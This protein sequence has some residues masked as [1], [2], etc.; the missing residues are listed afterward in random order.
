MKALKK[1]ALPLLAILF[2]FVS[3]Y[4]F[5]SCKP[6]DNENEETCDTCI[7]VYKPNIY[8]YPEQ[9]IDLHVWLEFPKGGKVITSI[10]EYNNGWDIHVTPNGKIN[11]EYNYLFYESSQ[12]NPFQTTEGWCVEKDQLFNFFT[13]NLGQYGFNNAEIKDFKDYWVPLLN[14]SGYYL[15][16]PQTNEII[17]QVIQLAFSEEPDNVLRLFYVIEKT[18][19]DQSENLPAPE[20]NSFSREGFVVTEWGVAFK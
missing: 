15:L 7:F 12:P 20:I 4:S 6:D 3:T 2:I 1:F 8:I 19:T 16:Y 9:E 18:E 13:S 11:N 17:D 14:D 10:P 5:Q